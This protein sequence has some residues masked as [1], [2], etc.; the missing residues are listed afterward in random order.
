MYYVY[1]LSSQPH[2]TLYIGKTSDLLRR[3][4]EH[5]SK[6]VL[7]FTSKYGVDQLVWF[8]PHETLEGAFRREKEIKQWKRAW[9]IQLIEKDNPHWIDL[10]Y[11]L[12]P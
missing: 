4:G 2:G 10:Y 11:S 6:A 7:G 9:K 8:E 3:V 1:L 12:S 5:K